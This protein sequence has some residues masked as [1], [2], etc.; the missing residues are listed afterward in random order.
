[1]SERAAEELRRAARDLLEL[2]RGA[3]P[4]LPKAALESAFERLYT[5]AARSAGATETGARA[6]RQ[7]EGVRDASLIVRH[8]GRPPTRDERPGSRWTVEM[9]DTGLEA[10]IA[11]VSIAR[12]LDDLYELL[13]RSITAARRYYRLGDADSEAFYL[14][15]RGQHRAWLGIAHSCGL[16][17]ETEARYD[18]LSL[19]FFF[20]WMRF[21][22]DTLARL[23]QGLIRRVLGEQASMLTVIEDGPDTPLLMY[24]QV[25]EGV[26]SFIRLFKGETIAQVRALL[27]AERRPIAYVKRAPIECLRG[28]WE[29]EKAFIRDG[30]R[31]RHTATVVKLLI[32][33]RP[34]ERP[35][36]PSQT[37]EPC[38]DER[39]GG[40]DDT[41]AGDRRRLGTDPNLRIQP[42]PPATLG[43]LGAWN[44]VH[45]E[46][47][48]TGAVD[49]PLL[50]MMPN[51]TVLTGDRALNV[52]L[53]SSTDLTVSESLLLEAADVLSNTRDLR[54]ASR[55][56]SQILAR[57]MSSGGLEIGPRGLA[58]RA[59]K[60]I[61]RPFRR[62]APGMLR[63]LGWTIS[64]LGSPLQLALQSGSTAVV[65]NFTDG[66]LARVD[67]VRAPADEPLP[68]VW[69][70]LCSEGPVGFVHFIFRP[71]TMSLPGLQRRPELDLQS[72]R[73]VTTPS[74]TVSP[75]RCIE[76]YP[77]NAIAKE[78]ARHFVGLGALNAVDLLPDL[79][80]R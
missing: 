27:A 7:L 38:S 43:L 71:G 80:A 64:L 18:R 49:L 54:S 16:S 55:A 66:D 34:D 74:I 10:L 75:G 33:N 35:P 61:V 53:G 30:H 22:G 12:R 9:D 47:A 79:F 73:L 45:V 17:A 46:P 36:A 32:G 48:S 69:M 25:E 39:R 77:D 13:Y 52:E 41:G 2:M 67:I 4:V 28:I 78:L 29:A 65:V 23:M 60:S 50:E 56:L 20:P 57:E 11:E 63:T 72:R 1:V 40:S 42:M 24:E 5:I 8:L 21:R 44:D 37:G 62:E 3:G 68:A 31:A 51:I 15:L 26:F 58:G 70:E 6:C 76:Y 14:W 19:P 59:V